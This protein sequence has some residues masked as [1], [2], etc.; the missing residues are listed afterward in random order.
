VTDPLVGVALTGMGKDGAAGT[1]AIK[2]AGG[3]TIAQDEET[4]PVFGIP[5]QAIETGCVDQV[6][7]ADE[8]AAGICSTFTQE[9]QTHG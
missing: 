7:P 5:K 9:G 6:L 1:E 4:S 2:A 3:T 8:I